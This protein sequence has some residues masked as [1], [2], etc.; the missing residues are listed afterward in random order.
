MTSQIHPSVT[1]EVV[2][3]LDGYGFDGIAQSMEILVNECMKIERQQSLGVWPYSRAFP[4]G[5]AHE[6]CRN[7]VFCEFKKTRRILLVIWFLFH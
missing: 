2:Q 5:V 7:V 6:V 1:F 4:A 3:V